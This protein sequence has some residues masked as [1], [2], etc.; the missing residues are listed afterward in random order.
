MVGNALAFID[1]RGH[2]LGV[3]QGGGDVDLGPWPAQTERLPRAP[4]PHQACGASQRAHR[5]RAAVER[6]A[7]D[8]AP[9]DQR[10][11]CAQLGG[12]QAAETPAG[13]PPM[14]TTRISPTPLDSPLLKV[15]HM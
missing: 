14:T 11:L 8:P 7:A 2:P 9:L 5:C 3:G 10:D 15:R 13:P 1:V 4:V 6:G 12:V